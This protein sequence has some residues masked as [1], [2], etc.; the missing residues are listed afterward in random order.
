M[1]RPGFE[2]VELLMQQWLDAIC[3]AKQAL[4]SRA[5]GKLVHIVAQIW[6][7][8]GFAERSNTFWNVPKE[9]FERFHMI[10]ATVFWQVVAGARLV[11]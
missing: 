3:L 10:A 1:T 11:Q 7:E 8:T 5:R 2:S 9:L 6:T 4:T